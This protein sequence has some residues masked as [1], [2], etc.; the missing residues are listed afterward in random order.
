MR[1]I[2]RDNEDA[3]VGCEVSERAAGRRR[4]TVG[5]EEAA[6]ACSGR[7]ESLCFLG[8]SFV[9]QISCLFQ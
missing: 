9:G 7:N 3:G 5:Y 2:K 4:V 6:K 8:Y 1:E